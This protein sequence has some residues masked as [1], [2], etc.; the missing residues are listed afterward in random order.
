MDCRFFD[1]VFAMCHTFSMYVTTIPIMA[2][3][4]I[5]TQAEPT[6]EDLEKAIWLAN[7]F[8]RQLSET[9]ESA[10]K[11]TNVTFHCEV[12]AEAIEVN[13]THYLGDA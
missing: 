3:L 11:A 2:V 13:Q 7:A 9:M 5:V 12:V 10:T 4:N 8:N 1:N 6:A